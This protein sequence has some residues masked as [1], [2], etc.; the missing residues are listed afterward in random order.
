MDL[1]LSRDA[2]DPLSA[3]ARN[4][5]GKALALL[6]LRTTIARIVTTFDFAFAPGEESKLANDNMTEGFS[7]SFGALM[8]VFSERQRVLKLG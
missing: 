2:D 1:A 8:I 3:G 5:I 7:T 4:C 6:N